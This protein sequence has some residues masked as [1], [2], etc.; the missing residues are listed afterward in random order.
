MPA[1]STT[2][3]LDLNLIQRWIRTLS[4]VSRIFSLTGLIVG[5]VGLTL[6][7]AFPLPASPQGC[8]VQQ[9]VTTDD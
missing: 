3:A 6:N 2:S 1:H 4:A 9:H 7:L 8:V 5:E